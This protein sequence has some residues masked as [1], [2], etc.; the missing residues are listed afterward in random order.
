M[1]EKPTRTHS[2]AHT[3]NIGI[4][5]H[6]DAG[7]TTTTERIL[8]YTGKNY[9]IGEVHEG[10]ATM[11][12]MEQEQERGI[13]IT[14]A[15]TTCFWMRHGQ[16]DKEGSGPEYRINIIDTPGHVDF[17]VEV[18]VSR[19]VDDVDAVLRPRA[20]FV[21]LA[22]THPE[23]GRGGRGDRDAALL[24]LL[25]PI[26]RRGAFMHLADLVVLSRIVKNTLGRR[27]LPGIDV[28]HDADV[29]VILERGNAC[30]I[31]PSGVSRGSRDGA[32]DKIKSA[33]A[34]AGGPGARIGPVSIRSRQGVTASHARSGTQGA[35]SKRALDVKLSCVASRE[36]NGSAGLR[37]SSV[38]N[39]PGSP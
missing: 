21:G 16:S 25:H 4:M 38:W 14:S 36:R 18:D 33:N 1:A 23:A 2:L 19:R 3:R 28:S 31:Y 15:A 22:V 24:L 27:R 20:L 34:N 7:K 11:D 13:T 32:S 35:P 17:T 30:H 8:Y 9:K 26:H 29:P 10:A 5:A 39:P 12:W 37:T 6:I